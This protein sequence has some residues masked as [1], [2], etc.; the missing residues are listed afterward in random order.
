MLFR[1]GADAVQITGRNGQAT[2]VSPGRLGA[3]RFTEPGTP[4]FN[5]LSGTMDLGAQMFLDPSNYLL[6]GAGKARKAMR[7]ME[8]FDNQSG[9]VNGIRRTVLKADVDNALN[10]RAGQGALQFL[11]ADTAEE[12]IAVFLPHGFHQLRT[13]NIA[14]T[15]T[16]NDHYAFLSRTLGD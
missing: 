7:G 2:G 4:Q 13:V 10:T 15:V 1:E 14:G 12:K 9:L 3:I 6:M 8:L 11:S 16:G 5:V